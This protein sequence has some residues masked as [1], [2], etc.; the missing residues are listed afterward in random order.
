MGM[1]DKEKSGR[2]GVLLRADQFTV[3]RGED[4]VFL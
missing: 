4:N 1:I 3:S 2:K